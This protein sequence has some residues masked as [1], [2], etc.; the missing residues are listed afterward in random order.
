MQASQVPDQEPDKGVQDDDGHDGG[1]PFPRTSR[2]DPSG[3]F[4]RGG[5]LAAF[6]F[7]LVFVRDRLGETLSTRAVGTRDGSQV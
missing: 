1:W 6:L 4:L 2:V 3:A 5:C 7:L